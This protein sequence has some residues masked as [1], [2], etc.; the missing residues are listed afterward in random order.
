MEV[1][2]L[3]IALGVGSVL[4]VQ[5]GKKQIR[6]FVGWSARETGELV[7]ALRNALEQAPNELR[8]QYRRGVEAHRPAERPVDAAETPRRANG[9][10]H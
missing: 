9:A 1:I 5:R 6:A 2:T 7:G 8:V 3:G 4:L 10:S